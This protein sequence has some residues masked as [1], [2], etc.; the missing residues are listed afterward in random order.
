[1]SD[2][3]LTYED[4]YRNKN[5]IAAGT[6]LTR[7]DAAGVRRIQAQLE[8]KGLS[9]DNNAYNQ[10]DFNE[11]PELR[12]EV[13]IY[14]LSGGGT[15]ENFFKI[16][17]GGGDTEK[18]ISNLYETLLA[19]K[20]DSEAGEK[21]KSF[22]DS[23]FTN[24]T[25]IK[26]CLATNSGRRILEMFIKSDARRE[27]LDGS[28]YGDKIGAHLVNLYRYFKSSNPDT[29]IKKQIEFFISVGNSSS[30][31]E[32]RVLQEMAET[33]KHFIANPAL[34]GTPLQ[35]GVF[36]DVRMSIPSTAAEPSF[37]ITETEITETQQATE[38]RVRL[39]KKKLALYEENIKTFDTA[40]KAWD[41]E[42]TLD[43]L[44]TALQAYLE[45]PDIKPSE[46]HERLMTLG[47]VTDADAGKTLEDIKNIIGG[48]TDSTVLE[49]LES[50]WNPETNKWT[51]TYPSVDLEE[52]PVE[53]PSS[54]AIKDVLGAS[55]ERQELTAD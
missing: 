46:P 17:P 55:S 2:M 38:L 48:I 25:F 13:L 43:T 45:I 5:G 39:A 3:R 1:M 40:L 51:L 29:D 11:K 12:R 44:K 9:N 30:T 20:N 26:E 21:V 31:P 14:Y 54:Q 24:S 7:E 47:W 28:R 34:G 4:L 36:R 27:S 42:R 33:V 32:V 18:F 49:G 15:I 22:L 10:R 53:N 52:E 37:E 16:S 50:E 35:P 19:L 23:K 8:G 6:K 41:A